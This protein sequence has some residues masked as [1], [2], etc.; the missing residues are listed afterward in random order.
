MNVL[1]S[2]KPDFATKILN[3]D[4]IYE[5]R[6]SKFNPKKR[7]NK[8][9]IYSSGPE[10]KIVGSFRIDKVFEDTPS[11]LWKS[12]NEFGGIEKQDFFKYYGQKEIG[13]AFKIKDLEVFEPSIDP[14]EIFENFKSPQNYCYLNDGD[15]SKIKTDP[16]S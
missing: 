5:F 8:V 11:N 12:F 3:G 6:K 1:L 15:T 14:R 4:K 2:I 7:V 16:I 13:Y 9:Y 10:K